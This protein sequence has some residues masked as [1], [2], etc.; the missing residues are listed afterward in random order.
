MSLH[1]QCGSLNE[2]EAEVGTSH[3]LEHMAFEGGEN[4]PPGS[5]RR[6]LDSLGM[7][8]GQH[9]NAY[10]GRESTS[11]TLSVPDNS[12]RTT[13]SCLACLADFAYGIRL[14]PEAIERERSI[15]LE[16]MRQ[17][18][19]AGVRIRQQ[20][21]SHLLPGSDVPR[22][23][24]FGTET[25]IRSV[26]AEQLRSYYDRWYRPESTT[27]LVTGDVE[28]KVIE[29]AL[30]RFFGDWQPGRPAPALPDL[31]IHPLATPEAAVVTDPEKKEVELRFVSVRPSLRPRTLDQ[32][33]QL[34]TAEIGFWLVNQR[35]G[36]LI[37]EGRAS[38]DG[39]RVGLA[40]LLNAWSIAGAMVLGLPDRW[41]RML[42]TLT[43][44]MKRALQYGFPAAEVQR[45]RAHVLARA[46]QSALDEDSATADSILAEMSASVTIGRPP[47]SG[48]QRLAR[49]ETVAPSITLD[50]LRSVFLDNFDP[51][52]RL[53]VAV[54]PARFHG[55]RP[56]ADELMELWQREEARKV[57]APRHRAAP[58]QLMADRPDAGTVTELH[59]EADL[60]LLTVTLSSGARVHLRAMSYCKDRVFADVILAGGRLRERADLVGMTTAASLAFYQPATADY[61][62]VR[63]RDTLAA[64]GI[65]FASS[66]EEDLVRLRLWGDPNDLEHGLQ[67]VHLLLTRPRLE[68]SALNRWR[69]QIAERN[70]DQTVSMQAQIAAESLRLLTG[71]DARFR[72]ISAR[73]A[74]AITRD[75]AQEWLQTEL[76]QAPIEVAIVG[77]LDLDKALELSA[78]YLGSLPARLVDDPDLDP[79]RELSP[80]RGPLR[81]T[82]QVESVTSRAAVLM[83]WRSAPWHEITHRHLQQMAA[84]ILRQRLFHELRERRTMTYSL[85]CSLSPSK[86][87]PEAS[88]LSAAF[89]TPP[90][91]V[92]EA[93]ATTGDIVQA[94]AGDGPTEAEMETTRKQYVELFARAEREPVFWSRVLAEC[95]YR[96]LPPGEIQHMSRR[97]RTYTRQQLRAVF[98]RHTTA[99]RQLS[100][101]CLPI[102]SNP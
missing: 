82:L 102:T 33:R 8:L 79:L 34:L 44:E 32:L 3:F 42:K 101:I 14:V 45:A 51:S 77:D 20:I 97:F 18:Q 41:Q 54:T 38:F 11:Y 68:A 62:S 17:H 74:R 81:S 87:Y 98:E 56:T 84:Q 5:L 7:R 95:D 86:A 28:A 22:R 83:G 91:R 89:Y 1:V 96:G 37:R 55:G 9:Y 80:P 24:V 29:A 64:R 69:R 99:D 27:L 46:K 100:V 40:P 57:S 16:E 13:E 88:M 39:M 93:L 61:S 92:E 2:L 15:I 70:E 73:Q 4:F 75:R 71:G 90:E 76:C 72:L 23:N 85:N 31:G 12:P 36:A 6:F 19:D 94:L 43:R 52:R 65:K 67:L 78:R 50:D 48:A 63:I 26:T 60:D 21:L 47:M 53:V 30:P 35:L 58:E 10:T 66:V 59:R 49:Y 25:V